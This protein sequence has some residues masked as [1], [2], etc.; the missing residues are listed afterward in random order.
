MISFANRLTIVAE[1]GTVFAY[2]AEPAHLP[3]WNHYVE[4]VTPLDDSEPRPG[5]RYHQRRR[6]DQQVFEIAELQPP[7]FLVLRT[8]PDQRPA[9]TRTITLTPLLAGGTDLVD[10]WQLD[11]GQPPLVQQLGRS[12]IRSAV[13]DNLGKLAELLETGTTTLQNGRVSTRADLAE[14]VIAQTDLDLQVID[15][16]AKP[17]PGAMPTSRQRA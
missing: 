17:V 10:H 3:D 8:L 16:M 12:T 15:G 6:N 1:P 4:Q 2:L 14:T 7:T 13:R 9:F 5:S 11:T